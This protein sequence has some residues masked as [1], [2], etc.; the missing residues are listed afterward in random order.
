MP[1][2][3]IKCHDDSVS[4]HGAYEIVCRGQP[5]RVSER[6]NRRSGADRVDAQILPAAP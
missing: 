2:S 4:H 5:A 6:P 3:V 1:G